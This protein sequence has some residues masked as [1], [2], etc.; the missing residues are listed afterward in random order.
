MIHEKLIE[1]HR[2]FKGVKASGV[3][4]HFKSEYIKLEDLVKAITLP[5]ADLGMYVTHYMDDNILHTAITAEDGELIMSRYVMTPSANPQTMGSQVTYAKR[6][7]LC[8]LLNIAEADDDGAAAAAAQPK[9][10]S[11]ETIA[12]LTTQIESMG[13]LSDEQADFFER[14]P[15]NTLNEDQAKKILAKLRKAA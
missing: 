9:P 1:F 11:I 8:A 4:P 2:Q 5:L 13:E 15:V 6:Y 12:A 7:N 14:Y 3:N 10:A